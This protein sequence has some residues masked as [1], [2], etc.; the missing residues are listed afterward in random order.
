M[1]TGLQHKPTLDSLL[2]EPLCKLGR[3]AFGEV[4]LVK[5]GS[6]VDAAEHVDGNAK[7]KLFALKRVSIAG[8][9]NGGVE[10]ALAEA[11]LLQRLGE[12]HECILRCWDFR[13]TMQPAPVLELLLDFAPLGDL[14]RRLRLQMQGSH[15]RSRGL[16]EREVLAYG[17]DVA[18]GLA[19]IHSLRPKVFHR[20]V[21][22]ANVVLFPPGTSSLRRDNLPLAKLADFGIA[23]VLESEASVAGTATFIGTPHY[24]SPEIF[25]GNVYDERADSWALG[26]VIYEMICSH[27][28]FHEAEGHTIAVLAYRVSEGRYDK[29]ALAS[30]VA[31][32]DDLLITTVE[33]LL[34]LEPDQRHRAQEAL[35][36]LR[37]LQADQA[38]KVE[39]T[40]FAC[41]PPLLTA[42]REGDG[43]AEGGA[44]GTTDSWHGANAAELEWSGPVADSGSAATGWTSSFRARAVEE[45][46]P[47]EPDR[48]ASL[49]RG[50]FSPEGRSGAS[51]R[52]A[53]GFGGFDLL[54]AQYSAEAGSRADPRS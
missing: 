31:S 54:K 50:A 34:A 38:L 36:R 11:R 5:V 14:G 9:S 40:V 28:P 32:Y 23:K 41:W 19:H 15:N 33:G 13:L 22:P 16:P 42:G 45:C 51:P 53:G 35:E 6:D 18:A 27:R 49:E 48:E 26:C 12:D 7:N 29:E 52:G 24:L 39:D 44:G 47:Y 30:Q 20:D 1:S 46:R 37:Q 4:F 25:K 21:K 2:A 3:G 10:K 8:L 17:C 43:F